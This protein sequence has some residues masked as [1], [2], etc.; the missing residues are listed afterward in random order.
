VSQSA[1]AADGGKSTAIETCGGSEGVTAMCSSNSDLMNGVRL[2]GSV[3]AAV[4]NA[5]A[6][7]QLSSPEH[8]TETGAF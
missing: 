5:E 1:S 4:S 6:G 3:M 8:T 2:F 7:G